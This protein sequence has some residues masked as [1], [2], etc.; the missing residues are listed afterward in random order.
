[1]KRVK[2]IEEKG[3]KSNK[4]IN[5]EDNR[6]TR[7]KMLLKHLKNKNNSNNIGTLENIEKEPK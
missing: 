5:I 2:I 1:M 6:W 3:E 7:R 4:R